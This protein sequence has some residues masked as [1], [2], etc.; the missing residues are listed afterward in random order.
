MNRMI[1][2]AVSVVVLLLAASAVMGWDATKDDN[3]SGDTQETTENDQFFQWPKVNDPDMGDIEM[4]HRGDTVAF[5]AVASMGHEFVRWVNTDGSTYSESMMVE[6]PIDD[7][8]KVTA[9]FRVLEGNFVVEYHWQMPVFESDGSD[10]VTEEVFTMAIDSAD[11]D[12]SIHDDSI[13]R[14]AGNGTNV[15]SDLVMN[16]GAVKAIAEYLEPKLEGLTNMQRAIV[17]M[18]FVQDAIDYETDASQYGKDEFWAT[19]LETVFSGRGDCEDTAILFVS[20]AE[21]LGL[22]AGL[23][24]FEDPV[25]GHM[26]AAVA[27]EEGEQVTGGAT[28]VSDG[29][30]YVYVE[31]AVDDKNLALGALSPAYDI[32]DGMWTQIVYDESSDSF[33]AF[34]PVSIGGVPA[35]ARFGMV[36]YGSEPTFSDSVSQPPTI[37]MQVGDSFTYVP[38]TSLPSDIVASGSGIVG[39]FGGSFL[40][41]D[42]ETNTLS[43]TATQPGHYTVTLSA[44]WNHGSLQQTAYQIIEFDVTAAGTDYVGQ[45]K[46]LTYSSGE[47]N[48]ETITT[49]PVDPD[50]GVP[51]AWIAAGAL[52][53]IVVGLIVARTV[54]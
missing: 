4:E 40:T 25:S 19:P 27:L 21:V 13:Q 24:S 17:V 18:C 53:V 16:D 52:A 23:V 11:W 47:W 22:D 33:S 42:P 9:E 28:F 10:V 15:P 5:S 54:V 31:T 20:L 34:G 45:D 46:E 48:I 8:G 7:V 2:A 51:L 50:D 44:T 3:G 6:F 49:E 32:A 43:G 26:S 14:R 39:T 12:A 29:M 35:T 30:T 38:T 36:T 41:W 37:P 1:L